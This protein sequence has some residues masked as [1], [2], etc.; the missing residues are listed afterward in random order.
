MLGLC[1]RNG[2]GVEK[3]EEMG[4]FYLT[5]AANLGYRDALAELR[6]VNPENYMEDIMDENNEKYSIPEGFSG[7]IAEDLIGKYEGVL[8]CMIGVVSIYWA[9]NR[10]CGFEIT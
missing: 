4:K 5:Q 6:H 8:V 3:D 10:F 1:Y 7:F 2:Y 9:R